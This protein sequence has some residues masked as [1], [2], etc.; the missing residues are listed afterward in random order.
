MS[1]ERS[2]QVGNAPWQRSGVNPAFHR[3]FD[4]QA[5][6][7]SRVLVPGCGTSHEP[8]EFARL[9]ARVTAID[10][11]PSAIATQQRAFRAAGVTGDLVCADIHSWRG[12]EPF[13]IVYE[14]TCLCAIEPAERVSYEATV[15]AAL[16]QDGELFALFMQTGSRGGPPFHCDLSDM[17]ALFGEPR[18]TWPSAS[19]L[20]SDHPVGVI[21]LGFVLRRTPAT[22]PRVAPGGRSMF[23][24]RP[25]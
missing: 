23:G 11:A 14:Q 13:D 4:G 10:I 19:P 6:N 15:A 12:Q 17:R 2:Y 22:Q 20:R 18:W 21:E 1:W 8:V 24:R 3:W 9:G 25:V 16:R 5:L 7:G